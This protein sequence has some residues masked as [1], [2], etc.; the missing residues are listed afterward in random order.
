MRKDVVQFCRLYNTCQLV[1]KP[2]QKPPVAPLQPIPAFEEHDSGLCGAIAKNEK[3]NQFLLTVMCASTRFPEAVPLRKIKVKTVVTALIKF[4]T[5]MGL[6]KTIQS[7][8][9]S[10]SAGDV[11]IEN[12]S[13]Q[14]QCLS[15]IIQS[16][17]E[18]WKDSTKP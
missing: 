13:D 3:G 1:G 7:D 16:H 9:E 14:I 12:S 17:K 18:H 8:Q 15:V 10:N 4:F 6:P 5:L 2:N 11:S